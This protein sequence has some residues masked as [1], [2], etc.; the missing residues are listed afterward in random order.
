M[1]DERAFTALREYAESSNDDFVKALCAG[2][3]RLLPDSEN[4]VRLNLIA[5]CFRELLTYQLDCL[6]PH[7]AVGICP[8]FVQDPT[9]RAATRRQRLR[10][11]IS[12]GLSDAVLE[13]IGVDEPASIAEL[14]KQYNEASKYTHVRPERLNYPDEEVSGFVTNGVNALF[15]LVEEISDLREEVKSHLH[16]AIAEHTLQQFLGTVFDELD[17]LSTHTRVEFPY[18]EEIDVESIDQ[19]HVYLSVT[20]QVNVELVYGSGSDFR[21]GDGATISDSFPFR[22][23]LRSPISNLK[24]FE[25]TQEIE[26]DTSSWYE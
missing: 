1:I 5:S 26:I 25:K 21:R 7:G 22:V 6:A 23:K 14:T 19:S 17:I 3:E 8:W 10:Y 24:K 20:G 11:A 18:V 4:P 9:V 15:E 2:M 16:A 12:G 13:E